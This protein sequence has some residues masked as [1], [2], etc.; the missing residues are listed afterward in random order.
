MRLHGFRLEIGSS[1]AAPCY[2]LCELALLWHLG[3]SVTIGLERRLWK[4]RCELGTCEVTVSWRGRAEA[5]YRFTSGIID[6]PVVTHQRC[7]YHGPHWEVAHVFDGR[8]AIADFQ[9]VRHDVMAWSGV[10]HAVKDG[11]SLQDACPTVPGRWYVTQ[12]RICWLK[13][14]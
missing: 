4:L 5:H 14:K 2:N 10:S 12:S 8:H 9:H 7:S 3:N 6:W 11:V 13:K 1:F